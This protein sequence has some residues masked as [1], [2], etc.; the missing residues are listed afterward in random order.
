MVRQ[1]AR[2]HPLKSRCSRIR[3]GLQKPLRELFASLPGRTIRQLAALWQRLAQRTGPRAN[4]KG[5]AP[6]PAPVAVH[7]PPGGRRP[8][9]ARRI[10][11]EGPDP[12]GSDWLLTSA[13]PLV[14]GVTENPTRSHRR[15]RPPMPGWR[16]PEGV[17]G[18]SSDDTVEGTLPP[19]PPTSHDPRDN[20]PMCDCFRQKQ[21]KAT[22]W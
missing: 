8:L 16:L 11:R 13:Y 22:P 12:V 14:P 7:P 20:R 18:R 3:P 17:S 1:G 21:V 10:A 15:L 9:G 6:S 19:A 5:T 2:K 4:A